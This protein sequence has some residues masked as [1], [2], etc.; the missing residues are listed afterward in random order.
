MK[1]ETN[2]VVWVNT[3]EK[4]FN[5]CAC[6]WQVA[7]D[8]KFAIYSHKML[9]AFSLLGDRTFFCSWYPCK[10]KREQEFSHWRRCSTQV[11]LA[12]C[13]FFGEQCVTI[14]LR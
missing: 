9:A 4:V 14:G 6:F 1:G 12:G 8:S 5:L 11:F 10:D 13:L 3:V 7:Q 2:A